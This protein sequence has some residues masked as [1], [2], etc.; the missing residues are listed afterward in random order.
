VR[1]QLVPAK[2]DLFH[3]RTV[4]QSTSSFE[5]IAILTFASCNR[6]ALLGETNQVAQIGIYSLIGNT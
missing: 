3:C 1:L 4:I 2:R 6:S 5:L